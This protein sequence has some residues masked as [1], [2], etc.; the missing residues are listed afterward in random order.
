MK[1]K[2]FFLFSC[3]VLLNIVTSI[4]AQEVEIIP[5]GYG[6]A[7][8][9]SLKSDEM[10]SKSFS[11]SMQKMLDLGGGLSVDFIALNG[12]YTNGSNSGS[13]LYEGGLLGSLFFGFPL[14]KIFRPYIGGGLGI[15]FNSVDDAYYFAWKAD[16]GLTSW[17]SDKMYL[18]SGA[19][20]DNVRKSFGVSVGIGAK[21]IKNVTSTYRNSNGSTFR[22]TWE[23][24]LWENNSTPNRIYGDTFAYSEF[25]RRYQKTTT[26]SSYSP[27]HY[28]TKT[29]GGEVLTTRLR[30]QYGKE[31]GTATTSIP[32]KSELVKTRDAEI[33]TFYYV[34]NVTVTR[35]WYTR[36][37][38]YKDREPTT[39]MVY[40]DE[41]T[42]VLINTFSDTKSR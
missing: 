40:K 9:F 22:R 16:V 5:W 39:E 25:V 24:Y 28:E 30:D 33:S 21:L 18:Q 27:A 32:V 35:K 23:R 14:G 19:T 8:S 41:E 6:L 12:E 11:I 37:W 10:T 36:T 2:Q 20:Y 17:F 26:S 7:T 31:I 4:F 1:R 42:A 15:G 34:Y 29:S 38:Y 13:G 3:L